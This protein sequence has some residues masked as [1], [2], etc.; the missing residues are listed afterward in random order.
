[1]VDRNR[2]Y[3][4]PWT[5]DNNPNGWIEPTTYC[6][7]KCPLCFRGV[8]LE[9]HRPTHVPLADVKREIDDLIRLRRVSTVTI[10]GGDPLLYPQLD[11]MIDYIRSKGVEAMI[12]TNGIDLDEAMLRRLK[13][14]SV[15]RIVI[16]IDRHQGR[17][18]IASELQ[19]IPL[20]RSFCDLFRK[21]G[22]VSLGFI[23]PVGFEDLDDLDVLLPFYKENADVVDLVTFN[24][25]QPVVDFDA[26]P[27]DRVL[28]GPELFERVRKVYG[29]EYGACLGKTHSDEIS[30]LFG[31]AIFAGTTYL[32]SLD[33]GAFRIFQENHYRKTGQ[34]LHCSRERHLSLRVLLRL[35]FN[36][37]LRTIALRR[38]ATR[39]GSAGGRKLNRQLV[40]IVN[41][42]TRLPNGELDRCRG[43]P[44]AMLYE[45][46]LVPSCV[47][48]QV[49][50][51]DMVEAG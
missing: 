31:Q 9:G 50:A 43:C 12:L 2:L 27:E 48:E 20:R 17:P 46:R 40:L 19:T 5:R 11:E 35:P 30:W 44:D 3:E 47:L 51:G 32:G 4:L 42:P 18:G 29:L 1:M 21:V 10:A 39:D 49:K 15:A 28:S 45:G 16:H 37:S 34:Y 22:G 7:L 24:R 6:Q 23:Q 25:M 13:A 38:L 14:R 41:T 36:R 26:L 8:D 33:K